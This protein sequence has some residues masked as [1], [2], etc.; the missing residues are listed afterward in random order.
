M[1]QMY[2]RRGLIIIRSTFAGIR[3]NQHIFFSDAKC[4][5]AENCT[6]FRKKSS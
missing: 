2:I 3:K 1:K 5:F 4:I 6:R